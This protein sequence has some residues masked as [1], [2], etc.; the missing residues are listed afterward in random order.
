MWEPPAARPGFPGLC[1]RFSGDTADGG[2][3]RPFRR[4]RCMPPQ[5]AREVD[6]VG[7][8]A[9]VRQDVARHGVAYYDGARQQIVIGVP[10]WSGGGEPVGTQPRPWTIGPLT[11]N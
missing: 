6:R 11:D 9:A 10:L 3:R 1:G 2:V 4:D 8:V 5:G 7:G